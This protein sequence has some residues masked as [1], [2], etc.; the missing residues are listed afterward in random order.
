MVALQSRCGVIMNRALGYF[1][2]PFSNLYYGWRTLN[3][4]SSPFNMSSAPVDSNASTWQP[5]IS[6]WSN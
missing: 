4:T 1:L 3:F 5:L 2:D 6:V